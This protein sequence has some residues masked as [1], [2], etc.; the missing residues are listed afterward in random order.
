[1]TP[2]S[3]PLLLAISPNVSLID[4]FS[5]AATDRYLGLQVGYKVMGLVLLMMLGWKVKRT[6]E[7]SL[8]K[9]LEGLL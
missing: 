4:S 8:E 7:Y 5:L 2:P 3:L 1:M 6:Q 9:R